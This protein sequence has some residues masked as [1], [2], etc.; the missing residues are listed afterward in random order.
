MTREENPQNQERDF[1]LCWKAQ[2]RATHIPTVRLL[3]LSSRPIVYSEGVD[4]GALQHI[5]S[6][7]GRQRLAEVIALNLVT[8]VFPQE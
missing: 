1:P 4:R 2:P 6:V 3:R 7:A 8:L 5:G